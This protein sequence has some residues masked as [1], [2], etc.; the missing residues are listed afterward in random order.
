LTL[1]GLEDDNPIGE[2]PDGDTE[3]SKPGFAER[4]IDR[5]CKRVPGMDQG[6]LHSSHGG[7]D[8]ITP[9]QR[10]ILGPAGPDGYYLNCGFSGTGFKIAPAVGACMA[11]L[12]VNGRS[13]TVDISPFTLSRFES[14]TLLKGV[15]SYENIWR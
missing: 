8:G 1:V 15:D 10:A 3:R 12:I 6:S 13:E 14:G 11:E 2:A 9:D 5:I 4:A 7:Y